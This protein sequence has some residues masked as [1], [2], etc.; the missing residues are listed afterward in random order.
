MP[1]DVMQLP[2]DAGPLV[3]DRFA[4]AYLTV[5]LQDLRA[6]LDG[7]CV[8]LP[9]TEV[10]PNG[11]TRRPQ[12]RGADYLVGIEG[13]TGCSVKIPDPGSHDQPGNQRPSVVRQVG[14]ATNSEKRGQ[15]ARLNIVVSQSRM[16]YDASDD[17]SQGAERG[18][19]P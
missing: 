12:N 1:N 4:G 19:P 11:P 7:G 2:G 10:Q 13:R 18:H 5:L 14:S 15:G 17:H 16:Q 6:P 3:G 8:P 9:N